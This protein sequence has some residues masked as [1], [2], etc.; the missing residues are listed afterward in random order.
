MHSATDDNGELWTAHRGRPARVVLGLQNV[1]FVFVVALREQG[2]AYYLAS[3][4]GATGAGPYPLLRPVGID[5]GPAAGPFTAGLQQRILGEVGYRVDTRVYGTRR[6]RRRCVE[7]LVRH[8]RGGGPDGGDRGAPR[9]SRGRAGSSMARRPGRAGRSTWRGC[10]WARAE[11]GAARGRPAG[12]LAPPERSARGAAG[13]RRGMRGV[14][15][16]PALAWRSCCSDGGCE[17]REQR[18]DGASIVRASDPTIR[19]PRGVPAALQVLDDGSRVSVH[20]DG[21]LVGSV[22]LRV[23]RPSTAPRSVWSWPATSAS[24]TSRPTRG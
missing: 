14:R 16:R 17:I 6:G 1:P 15:P 5:P 23:R 4:P 7:Q 22:W 13:D 11:S 12:G 19:L 3:V 20:V 2:A 8:G 21:R 18:A 10:G 24:A 9:W